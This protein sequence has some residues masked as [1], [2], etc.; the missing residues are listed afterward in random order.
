MAKIRERQRKDGT[1]AYQALVRRSGFPYRTET[2][3][4]AQ[5]RGW[6]NLTCSQRITNSYS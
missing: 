3:D 5:S 4:N 6:G 2:F 1:I